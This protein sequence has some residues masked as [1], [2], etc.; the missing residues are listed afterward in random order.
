MQELKQKI[1]FLS[2][3][4]LNE[5]PIEARAQNRRVEIVKTELIELIYHLIFRDMMCHAEH[6]SVLRSYHQIAVQGVR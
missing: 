4:V 5:I 2:K 1:R 3:P 6:R